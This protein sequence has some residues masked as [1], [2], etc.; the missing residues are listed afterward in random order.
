MATRIVLNPGAVVRLGESVA[1]RAAAR[2]AA[3]TARRAMRATYTAQRVRTGAMANSYRVRQMS[4][5]HYKVYNLMPY[6][7]YQQFGVGPFGPK[8]A[9]VLRFMPKGSSRVVFAQHVRGFPP[10]RMLE[11]ALA[12]LNVGDFLERAGAR[13]V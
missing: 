2:A 7:D 11:T 5:A 13:H 4:M 10:G 6:F 9:K 8:H 1:D 12:Q 3:M